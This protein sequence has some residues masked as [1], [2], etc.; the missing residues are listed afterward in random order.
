M[1]N[2]NTNQKSTEKIEQAK[3]EIEQKKL[4]IDQ[5]NVLFAYLKYL[6]ALSTGSIVLVPTILEK[7]F[8]HARG[9]VLVVIG[10]VLLMGSVLLFSWTMWAVITQ[11]RTA[12]PTSSKYTKR[13]GIGF[14]IG[15]SFFVIGIILT[16]V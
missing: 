8:Q 13:T 16:R 6:T 14:L 5:L 12:N 2:E 4:G 1:E 11:I 10:M 7:L 15:I 3:L 9:K